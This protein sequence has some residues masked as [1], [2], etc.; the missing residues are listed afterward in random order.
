MRPFELLNE[1]RGGIGLL[2]AALI[3]IAAVAAPA[4]ADS[5]SFEQRYHKRYL[6]DY[7]NY[8]YPNYRHNH[9]HRHYDND[10]PYYAPAPQYYYPPPV[11]YPEPRYY[12]PGPSFNL[13]IPL[14]D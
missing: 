13:T 11:Y 4:L 6:Y 2:F 5:E 12:Q 10:P 7:P 8:D 9:R 3:S 14:G 1:G